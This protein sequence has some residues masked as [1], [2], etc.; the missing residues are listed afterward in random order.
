MHPVLFFEGARRKIQKIYKRYGRTSIVRAQREINVREIKEK[1][2]MK[3]KATILI[4]FAVLM[5]ITMLSLLTFTMLRVNANSSVE[6]TQSVN[7]AWSSTLDT[8]TSSNG[9]EPFTPVVTK[10]GWVDLDNNG[11]ADTLDQEIA[12][13]LANGTAQEYV[14]VTVELKSEPT[15]DDAD[16]FVSCGGYVTTEPWT[17]A[18]YGF[19]GTIPYDQI[20]NF[21]EQCPDVLLV[22]KEAICHLDVAYA[23]QQIGAR[24]YVWNNLSLQGDPSSSLAILDTGIDASHVDFSPGWGNLSWS[25]KIVGWNNQINTS[26]LTPYD[27]E[28]HGSHCSGL[29]AGDGFFSTNSTDGRATTTWSANLGTISTSGTYLISGMMVNKAGNI[30]I[31]VKWYGTGTGKLSTLYLYNG[32]ANATG[33]GNWTNVASVN[34]TT[35]Q[36]WYNLTYNVASVPSSGYAMY[37]VDMGLTSGTGS[38]YAVFTVNWPYT[39]PSD[40]YSAWT[41]IAPQTKLVGVKILSNTGSGTSTQAI[42]GLNWLASNARTYHVTVASMSWGFSSETASVDTAVVN[43]VNAGVTCVAAAGNSG[44]GSNYIYTPGS[45]DQVITVAAMNQF[46]NIASYSSQGGSSH[47]SGGHTTKPDITAPGG[48]FYGLPLY[49]V[50]TNYNEAEGEWNE[51]V[52]NDSCPEQGTSMAT[53]IVAGAAELIVQAMGGYSNWTYNNVTALQPKMI[54][55]MTATETYPNLREG[56]TASTSPTLNRG[57][58]DVHEGYGRINVDAAADAV[59][60]TYGIGTTVTDTLAMPPTVSNITMLGQ[61]LAWARNVQLVSGFKYNFTL[62]VPAGADYDLYLYN[63]TGNTYGEPAIVANSTTATTGGTEKFTVTAPYTGKYYIVVKRATETTGSGTF[64]LTSSGPVSVTLNTPGLPS[65]SSVV[66]YTQN[67]TS[68]TGSIASYTFSDYADTGTTLSIDNPISVSFTE[69]Y[70]TT[71][72]TSFNVTSSTTFTVNYAHQYYLTVTSPYDVPTPSSG[73]FN[74]GANI[75][76]YVTSPVAGPTGTRYVCT[77]WTG[78]GSV[79]SSGTTTST[80][81]IINTGSNITWNWKTQYLITFDQTGVGGDFAG[82]VVTIDGTN[83]GYGDLPAAFWWDSGSPHTFAFQSS[84]TVT[85]DEKQYV[86]NTT[87]GTLGET[88][89]SDSITVGASGTVVGN[90]KTQWYLTFGETGVNSDFHGTV[91]IINGTGYDRNGVSFWAYDQDSYAFS[92]ESPLIVTPDEKQY[93]WVSTTGLSSV[94]SGVLVVTGAGSV[95]GNYKTQY[96]ITFD[97]TGVGG[98]FAGTVVTIDGIGYGYSGLPVSFWWDAGSVHSFSYASPLGVGGGK[99]YVWVSTTGLSGVQSDPLAVTGAGSVTGNYKTQYYVAFDQTGV[100]SDFTGSVVTID[101]S[102]YSATSLPASFWWDESSSH[103]F[104]FASPLRVDEIKQY[105]WNFTSGLSALQNDPLT[106]TASGSVIGNYIQQDAITFD[107]IGISSDFAATIAVIDGNHYGLSALP[108]SFYWTVGSTHYF[109]F[110]SPLIVTANAKQYV[111][112]STT[113]LSSAQIGSIT[114]ATYGSIIGNYKTQYYLA[115]NT[116]PLGVNSPTGEGWYDAGAYASVSTAQYDDIVPGSSRY[117][118]STWTTTDPLEIT[119]PTLTSTTVYM[120]KAK[121]VTANYVTQ[122]YVTFDQTGVG[123]DFAGTV[124]TIDGTSYGYSGLPVSFWWDA[125]SVHSFS[126]A[127]PLGVGGGKQYVW[128]STTGLSSAQSDPLVVMGAGSVIGNYKTQYYVTFDQLGVNLD[129]PG[130]VVTIDGSDYNLGALPAS[131]WWDSGSTHSFTFQSPLVVPPGAKQY[132]WASTSGLSTVQYGSITVGSTGSVVGHY[133]TH[134]HDVSVTNIAVFIPHCASKL[135]NSLWVFQGRPAYVNVTILNK[136][137]FDE[138]VTVTLYYNITDNKIAGTASVFIPVGQSATLSFIW[139]TTGVPYCH[140]Y[141]LTAVATIPADFVPSD[142]TLN[143]SAIKVR[144]LG[145]INGDGR[146]DLKDVYMVALSFGKA[147][148]ESGWN[149][150]CDINDDGQINLLDYYTVCL[151]FGICSS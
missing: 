98:D 41:G 15:V 109:A 96:Y 8:E 27:D 60:E 105:V 75:T 55:L 69:R 17:Y 71:N 129:F 100:G 118:F 22:E 9:S 25:S 18:T 54:L 68:K 111:W 14:N 97:Q 67:G 10:P 13:R 86:W 144:I 114:V 141:T 83:Y 35:A 61:R 88:V 123:S 94:Q 74:A 131:F 82:T 137:D 145:D 101:G 119:D 102:D 16:A 32:D 20:V 89:Q 81:F 43:L 113:G 24:T 127:S 126:Y 44:S 30:S 130:T 112:T 12:D 45:V 64:T 11:I 146:V 149:L 139:N 6:S 93:V 3:K 106:V 90:Y 29:A 147:P 59:L 76:E 134:V 56:G 116:S 142:N 38:I 148:G 99:Q 40:G 31:S 115:L 66:H 21:T 34:T 1:R 23:A 108:V 37:H 19:G 95:T 87:S 62:N 50:D 85:A 36:T 42:T 52:A 63:S 58:K 4:G 2:R 70:Y 80:T 65:A 84:L 7:K 103:S 124:V 117:S 92:F 135:D 150:D 57:G 49:S 151:N 143:G 122:Y 128:V 121:T 110:E 48:S 133:V 107:Q 28:G 39:P 132:D 136:G 47:E 104:S 33:T 5:L 138:S 91:V 140:N 53:P 46:D 72:T 79:P 26:A 51:T 78:T 77:G 73:W 125:G 120:D